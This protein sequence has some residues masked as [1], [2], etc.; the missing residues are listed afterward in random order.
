[1]RVR[2][3]LTYSAKT[4]RILALVVLVLGVPS[5][6]TQWATEGELVGAL[7]LAAHIY[8]AA[9]LAFFFPWLKSRKSA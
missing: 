6:A 5:A 2:W 4:Y 8:L 7:V 9:L 3:P 1:V